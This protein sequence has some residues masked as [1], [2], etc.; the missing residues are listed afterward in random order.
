MGQLFG[1]IP[2]AQTR[3]MYVGQPVEEIKALAATADKTYQENQGAYDALDVMAKNLDVH[4]KDYAIKLAQINALKQKAEEINKTGR[5][6]LAGSEVKKAA[7]DYATN[8]EL[9]AALASRQAQ[10]AYKKQLDELHD[11]VD[12]DGNPTISTEQYQN[13]LQA[14]EKQYK[15][16]HRDPVTGKVIGHF[17]GITPT[18]YVNIGAEGEK[19]AKDFAADKYG[20][21]YANVHLANEKDLKSGKFN[22]GDWVI[23]TKSGQIIETN[24]KDM[25][26]WIANRLENDQRIKDYYNSIGNVNQI[27]NSDRQLKYSPEGLLMDY[28]GEKSFT[29]FKERQI[30]LAEYNGQ[31]APTDNQLTSAYDNEKRRQA[32]IGAAA[33]FGYAKYGYIHDTTTSDVSATANPFSLK[34]KEDNVNSVNSLINQGQAEPTTAAELTSQATNLNKVNE[35]VK[36]AKSAL[37]IAT[38]SGNAREIAT[39]KDNLNQAQTKLSK[40]AVNKTNLDKDKNSKKE[41]NTDGDVLDLLKGTNPSGYDFKSETIDLIQ[42]L[43]NLPANKISTKMALAIKHILAGKGSTPFSKEQGYTLDKEL[44]KI[45]EDIRNY[46]EASN[47]F[48]KYKTIIEAKIQA[49]PPGYT[50]T[51]IS[52]GQNPALKIINKNKAYY[53]DKAAIQIAQDIVTDT[54]IKTAVAKNNKDYTQSLIAGTNFVSWDGMTNLSDFINNS[55]NFTATSD[56]DTTPSLKDS[57]YNMSIRPDAEGKFGGVVIFKDTKG[58]NMKMANGNI[59]AQKYFNPIDQSMAKARVYNVSQ[60]L[61]E[62]GETPELRNRGLQGLANV[63]FNTA[64]KLHPEKMD[65]GSID[66]TEISNPSTGKL[67]SIGIKKIGNNSF[68]AYI[69]K[70]E[71]GKGY[72][73]DETQPIDVHKTA[74]GYTNVFGEIPELVRDMYIHSLSNKENK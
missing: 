41:Y 56:K 33:G 55:D 3:S 47:I 26:D 40:L 59:N 20:R 36:L 16:I 19:A 25:R 7:K 52:L 67:I 4:D 64:Y 61:F 15:G 13:Y 44:T 49:D 31:P 35:D 10:G 2:F 22:V 39:A 45:G 72:V 23:T 51:A 38:K 27:L 73:I 9:N 42:E 14:S 12:K 70:R 71:E 17:Q 63:T 34:D 54:N 29:D 18:N 6:E 11:K 43:A 53:E 30:K 5:W 1:D 46:P 48:D 60:E 32:E 69:A 62:K 65:K 50:T 66:I 21:E 58:N 68:A 57:E 8:E 24:Q 37:D 74:T 28:D